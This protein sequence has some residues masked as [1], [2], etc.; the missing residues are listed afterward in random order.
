[1]V[2][3]LN[4]LRVAVPPLAPDK[5]DTLRCHQIHNGIGLLS[6]NIFLCTDWWPTKQNDDKNSKND[7]NTH[8]AS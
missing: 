5:L 3:D 2:I 7:S 8:G 1:M 4:Y 6:E